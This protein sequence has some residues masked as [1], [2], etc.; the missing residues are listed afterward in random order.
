MLSSSLT[1]NVLP[2]SVI[3]VAPHGQKVHSMS[4]HDFASENGSHSGG[5]D[6]TPFVGQARHHIAHRLA[7]A[8]REWPPP[9][10]KVRIAS[11]GHNVLP[12]GA[13]AEERPAVLRRDGP[14][15]SV[16]GPAA[17]C[18]MGWDRAARRP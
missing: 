8:L 14:L 15:N 4:T 18:A 7:A 6:Q 10:V 5:H 9:L 16:N 13:L 1:S 11:L 2:R 12:F 17:L 3:R